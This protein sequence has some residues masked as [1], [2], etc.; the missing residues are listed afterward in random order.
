MTITIPTYATTMCAANDSVAVVLDPSINFTTRSVDKEAMTWSATFPYGKISG[1]SACINVSGTQAV[2]VKN[3]T[4][5]VNGVTKTVVGGEQTGRYCWIRM[6]HPVVSQWVY[7][8]GRGDA[9]ACFSTCLAGDWWSFNTNGN[10][11]LDA[12]NFRR[13][14]FGS[15]MS[16]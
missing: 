4:H 7:Y 11:G 2:S 3:L 1:V 15:A 12:P 14:L 6:T 16:D 9:N 13:A 8:E 10:G 5:T